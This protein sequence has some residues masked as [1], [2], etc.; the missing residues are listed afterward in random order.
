MPVGSLDII[1]LVKWEHRD[2]SKMFMSESSIILNIAILTVLTGGGPIQRIL[3]FLG[4]LFL[5]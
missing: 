1:E 4:H 5:I 3:S 2:C